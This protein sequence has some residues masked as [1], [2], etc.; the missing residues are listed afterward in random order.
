MLPGVSF[1][2]SNVMFLVVAGRGEGC[3]GAVICD[4]GFDSGEKV[5]RRAKLYLLD[6]C[7]S[8]MSKTVRDMA[9]VRFKDA[10]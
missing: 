5:G 2:W 6:V 7:G 8:K 4:K 1:K 3:R 9:E 10:V